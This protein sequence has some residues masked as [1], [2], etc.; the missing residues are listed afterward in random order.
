MKIK[1]RMMDFTPLSGTWDRDSSLG[2]K[3]HESPHEKR[4]FSASATSGPAPLPR[5]PSNPPEVSNNRTTP[6]PSRPSTAH[7][8][9]LHDNNSSLHPLQLRQRQ[10]QQLQHLQHLQHQQQHQQQPGQRDEATSWG[11]RPES[12]GELGS[13]LLQPPPSPGGIDGGA[14]DDEEEWEAWNQRSLGKK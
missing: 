12:A 5:P 14:R 7:P 11:F 2:P 13:S 6:V 3:D 9:R 4:L 10:L 8:P 1:P